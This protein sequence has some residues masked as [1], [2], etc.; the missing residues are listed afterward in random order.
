MQHEEDVAQ[1]GHLM[2]RG[3]SDLHLLA[4]QLEFLREKRTHCHGPREL[5][6]DCRHAVVADERGLRLPQR[7]QILDEVGEFLARQPFVQTF[8][9]ERN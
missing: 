8:R 4:R 6:N 1:A 7:R 3:Q 5:G 2:K 9:H